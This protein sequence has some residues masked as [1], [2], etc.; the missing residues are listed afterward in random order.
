AVMV[1]G[2]GAV[3]QHFENTI[4]RSTTMRN[5][6]IATAAITALSAGAASAADMAPRPYVKAPPIVDV[7]NWTGFY[8]GGNVG[9][10]W[11]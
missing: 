3:R 2:H 1:F 10:Q 11:L 5:F 8:I 4:F 9:G 6:L 7:Y